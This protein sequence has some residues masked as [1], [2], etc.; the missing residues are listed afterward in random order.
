MNPVYSGSELRNKVIWILGMGRSGLAAARL[1]KETGAEV[2]VTEMKPAEEVKGSVEVLEELGLEYETGGHRLAGRALPEF[3]VISPGI[4]TDAPVV[5]WLRNEGRPVFSEVE[6]ASWFYYGTIIGVTGSNG[7]TTVASWTAHILRE[8]GIK[9]VAT[10]NI[11]YPFSDMVREQRK[12]THAVVE[13]SSYQLETI[14]GFRPH[15]AVLTNITPDHLERHGDIITYAGTKARIW[16]NQSDSDW[17]VLP[18]GDDLVATITLTIRPQK[19]YVR[20]DY[21]PSCGAGLED[22]M[23]CTDLG[24]GREKLIDAGELPLPGMHNIANALSSAAACRVLQLSPQEIS[25]GLLSFPG[26]PHRLEMIGRNGRNWINDSKSTNVD[27]LRVALESMEGEIWLIAGGR[28]KGSSFASLKP[29]IKKYVSRILLIGEAAE[30]MAAEFGDVARIDIC[31]TVEQAVDLAS[32][33][34]PEGATVLLSPACSS[35]DQ[36]RDYEHRGE[37]FRRLVE[38]VTGG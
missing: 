5:H 6:V 30:K 11:G 8:A 19:V 29:L 32:K 21:C 16:E 28:D 24:A 33:Q 38:K 20:L 3:A 17:V 31:E 10:G 4:P 1:L 7:K 9:A 26:V 36:F 27:S 25:R 37:I 2:F 18:G 13:V 15:V 23:L 14:L 12:A 22:G 35:F 34:A